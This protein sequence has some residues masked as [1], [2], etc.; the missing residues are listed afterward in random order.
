MAPHIGYYQE[1]QLGIISKYN[2]NNQLYGVIIYPSNRGQMAYCLANTG[3]YNDS[4]D[5]KVYRGERSSNNQRFQWDNE[6]REIGFFKDRNDLALRSLIWCDNYHMI[7]LTRPAGSDIAYF[8]NTNK[9]DVK[10]WWIDTNNSADESTWTTGIEITN[11]I[12]DAYKNGLNLDLTTR[13]NDA[14]LHRGTPYRN[15]GASGWYYDEEYDTFTFFIYP[16]NEYTTGRDGKNI[17]CC[18]YKRNGTRIG[19]YDMGNYLSAF[20]FTQEWLDKGYSFNKDSKVADADSENSTKT[21]QYGSGWTT[22]SFLYYPEKELC[23]LMVNDATLEFYRDDIDRKDESV[24]FYMRWRIPHSIHRGQGGTITKIQGDHDNI[25]LGTD[26]LCRDN[27]KWVNNSIIGRNDKLVCNSRPFMMQSR[28]LFNNIIYCGVFFVLEYYK[29]EYTVRMGFAFYGGN[30]IDEVTDPKY[31]GSICEPITANYLMTPDASLWGKSHKSTSAFYD[32]IYFITENMK[33]DMQFGDTDDPNQYP[34]VNFNGFRCKDF[35]FYGEDSSGCKIILPKHN[36]YEY[37]GDCMRDVITIYPEDGVVRYGNYG[38]PGNEFLKYVS[39][40]RYD[41]FDRD[42]YYYNKAKTVGV[43]EGEPYYIIC[44]P[45]DTTYQGTTSNIHVEAISTTWNEDSKT[46][47]SS[48]IKSLDFSVTDNDRFAN[49]VNRDLHRAMDYRC[50]MYNPYGDYFFLSL[51]DANDNEYNDQVS[52]KTYFALIMND[53]TIKPFGKDFESK[54]CSDYVLMMNQCHQQAQNGEYYK[55]Q[56]CFM[57][58]LSD[59]K[60]YVSFFRYSLFSMDF[61]NCLQL[62]I[63][64]NNDY[65]DFTM[66]NC[67][68]NKSSGIRNDLGVYNSTGWTEND[69]GFTY[70]TVTGVMINRTA[71]KVAPTILYTQK[72]LPGDTSGTTYTTDQILND[73]LT[74]SNKYAMY[75]ESN[76]FPVGYIPAIPI[77]LGGYFSIIEE[78]IAIEFTP[79]QHNYIYLQRD[80]NDK[81]N[82]ICEIS[83]KLTIQE[84]EKMFSRICVADINCDASQITDVTYYHINIGYNDYKWETGIY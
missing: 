63:E 26:N 25:P 9:T 12:I 84:G 8:S 74:N 49:I 52:G 82:I 7:V 66:T 59:K 58:A 35:S 40:K 4:T 81:T 5:L 70:S 16:L 44:K 33:T 23:L 13:N 62:Y 83:D 21:Q 54:W 53:G 75:L 20:R 1:D 56:F 46:F 51:T 11:I 34:V 38:F 32:N 60:I 15:V 39:E 22:W 48:V 69:I 27:H 30:R 67:E 71:W 77:F 73:F 61:Y 10:L 36:M 43:K 72:P 78:P 42:P 64:F 76:T 24:D 3:A 18:V 14:A 45:F 17:K 31:Q 6:P 47:E 55:Q 57:V 80:P 29:N 37:V 79:S 2:M 65:S 50:P 41:E 28:D 19:I 68:F